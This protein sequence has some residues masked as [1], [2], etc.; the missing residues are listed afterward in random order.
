MVSRRQLLIA[1]SAFA[2]P[3]RSRAATALPAGTVSFIDPATEFRLF[4]LTDPKFASH[5]P[6][7]QGVFVSKHASFLLF[8]NDRGGALQPYRL[9]IKRGECAQIA[10]ADGLHPEGIVLA[11][12]EKNF[13]YLDNGGLYRGSLSHGRSRQVYGIAS[14]W[15]AGYGL[16][17]SP[18]GL[19]AALIEKRG[20]Q[21]R[22]RLIATGRGTAVTLVEAGEELSLP[23][24]RPK[25]AGVLYRRAP[26]SLWLVNFDGAGNHKLAAASDTLGPAFWS[27]DGRAVEYLDFPSDR[28]RPRAIREFAADF[29]RDA[30]VANTSQY[31]HFGANGDGSVFVGASASKVSPYVLLMLRSTRR[32]LTICEHRASDPSLVSPVFSPD[33]QRVFFQSDKEG[34][35]AIYMMNVERLVEETDE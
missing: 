5:L 18:D 35:M 21:Y 34:K 27:R 32:E 26:G 9:D 25:R 29:N 24:P 13:Y 10:E 4:R 17:L 11:P 30:L 3:S 8:S 7:Y 19:Y 20:G 2:R 28:T 14:G 12:D 6:G 23:S 33:S 15:E 1:L 31:A 16:G 22:I